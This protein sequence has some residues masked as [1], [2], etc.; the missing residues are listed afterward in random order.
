MSIKNLESLETWQKAQVFA[1]RIYQEILP[2]LPVEEKWGLCQQIRRSATSIPANIAEGHGRYYFQDNVHFCYN[3]RG[4]LEET[5]SHIS[6]CYQAGYV[7]ENVYREMEQDG[8][9]LSQ[10]INGYIGFLKRSKQ[11]LNEPGGNHAIHD[12]AESEYLFDGEPIPEFSTT[13][14]E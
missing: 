10:L 3:A 13:N 8:E 11:G 5:L 1:L 14:N 6:F 4:S 12:S 7:S 2:L 9:K